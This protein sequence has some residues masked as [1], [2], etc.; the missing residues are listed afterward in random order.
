MYSKNFKTRSLGRKLIP[1]GQ[2]FFTFL[3]LDPSDNS[4]CFFCDRFLMEMFMEALCYD[5]WFLLAL[6]LRDSNAVTQCI[7]KLVTL[8]DVTPELLSRLNEGRNA[9]EAWAEKEW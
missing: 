8:Q 5:W 7:N 3:L 1:I 2:E 4:I 9:I 6:V